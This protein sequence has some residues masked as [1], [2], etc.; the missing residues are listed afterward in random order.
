MMRGIVN[1]PYILARALA[2]TA[3]QKPGV[4]APARL[5]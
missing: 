5:S 3:G 2:G 1:Y 4:Y